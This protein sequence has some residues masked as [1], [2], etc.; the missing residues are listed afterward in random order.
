MSDKS[1][2]ASI[3]WHLHPDYEI[4]YVLV[5]KLKLDTF[6]LIIY[7][8]MHYRNI[9]AITVNQTS[10][11]DKTSE[12]SNVNKIINYIRIRIRFD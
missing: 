2:P 8:S 4:N 10:I 6:Q 3:N 7:Q 1:N 9:I 5:G 12:T 11:T